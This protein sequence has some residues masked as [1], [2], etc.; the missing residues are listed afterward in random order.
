[1]NFLFNELSMEGQF[2]NTLTFRDAMGRLMKMRKVIRDSGHELHCHREM[3]N[4][5]V[6]GDAVFSRAVQKLPRDEKASVMQWVTRQGPFWEDSRSHGPD[7]W[8]E[9]RGKIVTDSAI[10]EAAYRNLS[11]DDCHLVSLTPSSWEFSPL[12]VTWRPDNGEQDI[13]IPNHW[14]RDTLESTLPNASEKV[15]SWNE[16]EKLS[17]GRFTHLIFSEEGFSPLQDFPFIESAAQRIM[18]RFRVLDEFKNRFD[19]AGK[20]TR[21]GH[22]I[23]QQYFTGEKAWF[24]DSSDSEKHRFRDELTFLHPET[25]DALFCPWHGKINTN[26]QPLRI[27]FSYPVRADKPLYVVYV[28]PKLTKR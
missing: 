3:G 10:G 11:G 7:E 8:L 4:A 20:R 5:K 25:G 17:R 23:Y 13:D 2:Q 14:E 26:Q 28:G 1:M 18:A 12:S 27:H 24:S 21:A 6:M 16:L 15:N 9:C 22:N 19:E